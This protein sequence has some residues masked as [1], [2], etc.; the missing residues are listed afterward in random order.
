MRQ[1]QLEWIPQTSQKDIAK[2]I[3][4]DGEVLQASSEGKK[5][6]DHKQNEQDK[7]NEHK[8]DDR[9]QQKGSNDVNHMSR[10]NSKHDE[11]IFATKQKARLREEKGK[12]RRRNHA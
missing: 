5:E 4:K 10:D 1:Q 8:D 9:W 7:A 2:S 11:K 6:K 12:E 3:N